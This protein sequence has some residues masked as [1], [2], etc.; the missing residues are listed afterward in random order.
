MLEFK[1]VPEASTE[2]IEAEAVCNRTG[3]RGAC[4][5]AAGVAAATLPHAPCALCLLPSAFNLAGGAAGNPWVLVGGLGLSGASLITWRALKGKAATTHAQLQ[6]Y[7]AA[8]AS[9]AVAVAMNFSGVHTHHHNHQGLGEEG[10][11]AWWGSLS[12]VQQTTYQQ[13]ADAFLKRLAP[14]ERERFTSFAEQSSG[15]SL[16]NWAL[17]E[18][19]AMCGGNVFIEPEMTP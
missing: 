18:T 5:C 10:F 11:N 4:E 6:M 17:R 7:G 2:A 19:S 1:P 16:E 12:Q 15:L 3:V 9:A 8:A 14:D 13:R